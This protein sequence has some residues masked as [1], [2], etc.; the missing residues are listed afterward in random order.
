MRMKRSSLG[1]YRRLG[2]LIVSKLLD[3]VGLGAS[4]DARDVEIALSGS[5]A[6]PTSCDTETCPTSRKSHPPKLDICRQLCVIS[7]PLQRREGRRGTGDDE[8]PVR[9]D[10]Q[11]ST[12]SK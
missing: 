11:V 7:S 9:Y 1:C 10:K 12:T 8:L 3:L 2:F 5:S 4:P 6:P